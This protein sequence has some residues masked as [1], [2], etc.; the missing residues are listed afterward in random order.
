MEDAEAVVLVGE[1]MVELY[2]T[3]AL[4]GALNGVAFL[5]DAFLWRVVDKGS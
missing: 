3:N 2:L 4:E 1:G 5:I